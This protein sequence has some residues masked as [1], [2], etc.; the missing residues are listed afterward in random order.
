MTKMILPLL[1]LLFS[2]ALSAGDPDREWRAELARLGYEDVR[3]QART[4]LDLSGIDCPT[5]N[6]EDEVEGQHPGSNQ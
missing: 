3:K 4:S 2:P 6:A 5:Q 1:F